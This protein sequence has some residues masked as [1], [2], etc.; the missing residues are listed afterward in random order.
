MTAQI[1]EQIV[2]EGQR[3]AMCTEPLAEYF[4]LGGQ[5]PDFAINCTAL[6]RGYIGTWEV[7][8]DR[9]YLVDL[10]ASLESGASCT[11]ETI[12]PGYPDQ[13]FAHWYS[14]TL[15]IPDGG[16]LEY[17][18]QGYGSQYERDL[19]LHISDGC[20]TG[21]RVRTN[22]TSTDPGAPRGGRPRPSGRPCCSRAGGS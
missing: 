15:R 4:A 12:F 22:G 2:L 16:L 6:W 14:G 13:V 3:Y 11:L 10:E 1:G 21:R 18:H 19:L 9:L 5:K 17:V 20:L 7:T 8:N